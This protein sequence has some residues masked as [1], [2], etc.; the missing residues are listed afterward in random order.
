MKLTKKKEVSKVIVKIIRKIL[1]Y[2]LKG[3]QGKTSIAC[4]LSLE[5]NWPVITNDVHS[6]LEEILPE[7]MVLKL[8]PNDELPSA[9]ELG[10]DTKEESLIFDFGGYLDPRIITALEISDVVIIPVSDFGKKLDTQGF[11]SS[12]AEAESYNK[13]IVIVLNK[14]REED[15]AAVRSELK[16]HKYSYPIFELRKSEAVEKMLNEKKSISGIVK[17]GG[18]LGWTYRGINNDFTKLINYIKGVK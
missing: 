9:D 15:A 1:L 13:N 3:G 14:M 17:E 7:E 16:K 12:I 2:S 10:A 6:P 4:A 8:E 5:L 11:I 18:L